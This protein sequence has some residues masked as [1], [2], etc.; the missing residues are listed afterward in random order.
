MQNQSVN[1]TLEDIE[2]AKAKAS[3]DAFKKARN[4]A[5]AVATA[6]GRSLGELIVCFR[7]CEP[8][9]CG[10]YGHPDESDVKNS[11]RCSHTGAH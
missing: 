3:E 10:T 8:T 11:R 2:Q 5:A 1:Y 6:S 7:R 9:V 4:Q